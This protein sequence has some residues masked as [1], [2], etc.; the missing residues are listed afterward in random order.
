MEHSSP[1]SNSRSLGKLGVVSTHQVSIEPIRVFV[2]G[3]PRSGTTLLQVA[4]GSQ[5]RCLVFPESRFFATARPRN[6]LA[7]QLGLASRSVP[8]STVESLAIAGLRP[9]VIKNVYS[10][11]LH[12]TRARR[13]VEALDERACA[14]GATHWLEK[15][16]IHLHYLRDIVAAVP[17]ARFLHVVRSPR[18]AIAS[19]KAVSDEYPVEWGGPRTA[20]DC[21]DRWIADAC[22]TA[23][24]IRDRPEA[25]RIVCYER[26]VAS[27]ADEVRGICNWI[28]LEYSRADLETRTAVRSDV[29]GAAGEE[30]KR[31]SFGPVRAQSSKFG[32]MHPR[33]QR[34]VNS[35]L[36][37]LPKLALDLVCECEPEGQG[38]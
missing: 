28:G 10:A 9:D 8:R 19:L 17:E 14:L 29:V 26:L 37:R 34:A 4:L 22:R 32:T 7:R 27:T 11:R 16:P 31:A 3:T 24:A 33:D 15:T 25:H 12:A 38:A 21:C 18:D 13:F 1:V 20:L 35:R 30:W 6:R 23:E 2:V 36:A 5:Q